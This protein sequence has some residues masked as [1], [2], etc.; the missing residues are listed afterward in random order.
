MQLHNLLLVKPKK[1]NRSTMGDIMKKI[2]LV[3][4]ILGIGITSAKAGTYLRKPNTFTANTYFVTGTTSD[5]PVVLSSLKEASGV[6]VFNGSSLT[7]NGTS[8]TKANQPTLGNGTTLSKST[9]GSSANQVLVL[10]LTRF[11]LPNVKAAGNAQ[12]NGSLLLTLPTGAQIL[13]GTKVALNIFA[14]NGGVAKEANGAV[15]ALGSAKAAGVNLSLVAA[16]ATTYDISGAL[17]ATALNGR[18]LTGIE[19]TAY[20]TDTAGTKTVYL[21]YANGLPAATVGTLHV[22][23]SILIPITNLY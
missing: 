1:R 6:T 7:I 14:A 5:D 11:R 23:G 13:P 20:T 18:A 15:L 21:N 16:G 9:K 12:A 8:L 19:A 10:T 17:V 2:I 3:A 4:A 22:N